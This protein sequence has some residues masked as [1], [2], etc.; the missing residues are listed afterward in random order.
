MRERTRELDQRIQAIAAERGR[1]PDKTITLEAVDA[2]RLRLLQ[3]LDANL[4][5]GALLLDAL[6]KVTTR[7]LADLYQIPDDVVAEV[8]LSPDQ[9]GGN[10]I[11]CF[12]KVP[13]QPAEAPP[14]EVAVEEPD[15][16]EEAQT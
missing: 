3:Q 4:R 2:G 16:V 9:D 7:D 13:P 11:V 8:S 10:V 1:Q 5:R 6:T 12:S 14:I 15:I